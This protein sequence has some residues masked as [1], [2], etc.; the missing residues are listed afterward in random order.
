MGKSSQIKSE[1]SSALIAHAKSRS[2]DVVVKLRRAMVTIA[3]EIEDNDGCYLLNNGRLSMAEVCR[4]A[5]VHK[6]T[7]QGAAHK[8]TTKIMLKEWLN[9]LNK[10]IGS[11]KTVRQRT[12]RAINDWK[13]RYDDL[14]RSYNEMYAIEI[15]ARDSKLS[16]ALERVSELEGEVLKLHAQLS[17]G[18]VVKISKKND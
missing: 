14:A 12:S 3:R 5:A 10:S 1:V 7:L 8:L 11:G 17:R 13:A 6:I 9:G 18:N 2:D 15:V 16:A 4:R